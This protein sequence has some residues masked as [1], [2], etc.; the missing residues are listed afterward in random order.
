MPFELLAEL[1]L[2]KLCEVFRVPTL[3][4]HQIDTGQNVL[5]GISTILDV[6]TGGGKT[7]AYWYPLFYYWAPGNTDENCQKIILV[8]GLLTALMQSQ[9][10]RLAVKGVPAVAITS[11]RI[12]NDNYLQDVGDNK[13]C[14][15]FVSPEMVIT[16]KFQDL[17]LSSKA[18]SENIICQVIDEGHGIS[19]WGN[20][21]FRP[22]FSQLHILLGRLPSGLPVVVGSATMPRD[23]ILDILAKLR[24][25]ADCEHISVSNAKPNITLSMRILQHPQDTFADLMT[26][27]SRDFDGPKDF[28]QTLI[29]AGGCIEVEKMQDFL[30]R[31]TP[32]HIDPDIFEFYHRFIAEKRKESVQER[33]ENGI[34]RGV[35]TTDALGMGMDFQ[36]IMRVLLWLVPRSFLS[37]V[38]KIGRCV[39]SAELLG[40]AI[41]YITSSAFMRYEIEL[42]ILKSDMA[43][44]ADGDEALEPPEQLADGEQ[45]DRDAAAEANDDTEPK[46]LPKR[47]SKKAMSAMEARDRRLLLGY[48]VTTG[49]IFLTVLFDPNLVP[50]T[51]PY[52]APPGACCCD[53]CTPELFRVPTI[54]PPA[55]SLL[56]SGRRRHAKASDE[57]I[58]EAKKTLRTLRNVIAQRDFPNGLIITGKILMSDVVVEGLAPRVRD[59]TSLEALIQTVRWH[60][61]PRYGAEVV[62][63]IQ[64]LLCHHPDP[65]REAREAQQQ[66]NAFAT[67]QALAEADLRNK[68][69]VIFDACHEAILCEKRPA[70]KPGK[71][72]EKVCQIFMALPW[73]TAWPTYYTLIKYPMSVAKIKQFSHTKHVKSTTEY[74]ALWH[75]L[76]QNAQE[77]NMEGLCVY[78][79]AVFLQRL[80]DNTLAEQAELH[81]MPGINPQQCK[82]L[83]TRAR[84]G[85]DLETESDRV[86]ES[87]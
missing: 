81:G 8:V 86:L 12:I 78:D 14:I 18:F 32:E 74:A 83:V 68:L 34:L 84:S 17:V 13:Y 20:D 4:I 60:W 57:L 49:I 1:D 63:A 28:P 24:L 69:V 43:D 72:V 45:M 65:E 29:Y 77:F 36:R 7:L 62:A 56:K 59:I 66:E 5:K 50:V 3:R 44:D 85:I 52:P 42:N 51:L 64:D 82:S 41:L 71:P 87:N 22:E 54:H 38:Q 11:A 40:E 55:G 35:S 79:D 67:L 10:S 48:I 6:P 76:F 26:T 61:A 53:N 30:R 21:D 9:A 39:R 58:N 33:V 2:E 25:R 31:N 47:K 23:V 46:V 80:L 75:I 27:F 19:K 70:S 73:K 16:S 15:V 37:P